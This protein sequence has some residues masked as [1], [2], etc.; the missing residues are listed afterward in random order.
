MV[1]LRSL[2]SELGWTDIQTYIQS[3]NV[4][5]TADASPAALQEELER[6][7]DRRFGFSVAVVVRPARRWSIYVESNPFLGAA[8]SRPNLVM[9][10]LS[11]V[12]PKRDAVE[13]LKTRAV[14]GER[15]VQVGDALWIDFVSG[16]GKSKLS[17]AVFDRLV[18][19]AV[20]MR[21]WRT[22]LKLN[23]LVHP[24]VS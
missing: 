14:G 3:G 9:L 16:A 4:I 18:G 17:P 21:N 11:K 12:T 2:C 8:Q 20:T 24:A 19:S 10:A 22:V 13:Q 1:E 5:F 23:D 7:I 15:V 6:A